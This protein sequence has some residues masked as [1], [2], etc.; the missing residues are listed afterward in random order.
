MYRRDGL[1]FTTLT[2]PSW[3]NPKIARIMPTQQG[4]SWGSFL[5]LKDTEW[6]GYID[7]VSSASIDRALRGD[8]TPL[9]KEGLRDPRGCLRKAPL[10][11]ECADA[12]G[13]ASFKSTTCTASSKNTPECFVIT[14]DIPAPVRVL[15]SAWKEGYYVVREV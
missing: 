6:A 3:A 10:S 13:C 1:I 11:K 4:G 15:L 9:M 2:D 5:E 14:R 12:K 8:C 7:V